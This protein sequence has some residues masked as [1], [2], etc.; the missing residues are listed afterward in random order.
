MGEDSMDRAKI[1]AQIA[2][3]GRRL[4][5]LSKKHSHFDTVLDHPHWF[6]W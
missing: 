5:E 2:D 3:V 6:P 4:T 1:T